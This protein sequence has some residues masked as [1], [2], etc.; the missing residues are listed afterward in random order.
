MEGRRFVE[1]DLLGYSAR[2]LKMKLN[3]LRGN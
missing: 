1:V 2:E 3:F